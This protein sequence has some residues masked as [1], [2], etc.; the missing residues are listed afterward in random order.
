MLQHEVKA[1]AARIDKAESVVVLAGPGVVR[2]Q[3]VAGLHALAGAS[4]PACYMWGAKGVFH[5]QS[6][7]H[8]ATI[9]L[10][11]TTS[12]EADWVTPG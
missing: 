10:Q 2:A 12:C 8:W 3:S 9:G 11:D 7:H 4:G 6:R 1:P 5:W